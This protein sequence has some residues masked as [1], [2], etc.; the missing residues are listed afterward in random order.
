MAP[1]GWPATLADGPVGLRPLRMRDGPAWV[2]SRLRNEAWLAPWEA[3]TP[4]EQGVGWADRHTLAVFA[5]TVRRF[6]REARAGHSLPFAVTYAGG[7]AGQLTVSSIARGALASAWVGYWVDQRLAGRGIMPT[8]LA[9][10]ADH[11]FTVV[12]LHRLEVHIRPENRSSRRVVEKLGFRLEGEHHGYLFIDGA[13][14]DHLCYALVADEVWPPGLLARWRD[15]ARD[16]PSA[17]P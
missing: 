13:Y 16:T 9:L 11:C 8:A 2:E 12:G 5:A 7:L 10:A 1:R 4:G 17:N 6:R 3:S 15:R 14:R